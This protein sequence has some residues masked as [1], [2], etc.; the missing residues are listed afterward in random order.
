M[1]TN[2]LKTLAACFVAALM[3]VA[4]AQTALADHDGEKRVHIKKI[5]KCEDGDCTE[6]IEN[7]DHGV[8]VIVD[9]D[10]SKR[11]HVKKIRCDGE[12]CEEHDGAHKMI[13][14]GDGDVEIMSGDEGYSWFSG[15]GVHGGGFLGVG[16]TELTSE[17]REHFGAPGD[18]GVMVSKVMDNSPAFKAGL[19]VGDIITGVDGE[20][21]SNGSAL[22]RMI[23][24]HAE[25]DEVV[26]SVLR[27]GATQSITAAIEEREGGLHGA[28]MKR[29]HER[30][31][32]MHKRVKKIKIQCDSEDGDCRSNVD[33]AGLDDFD[34]GGAEECEVHVECRDGDCTCTVNGEDTDCSGIPGVPG[35]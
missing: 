27:D 14:V 32:D 13:F 18:A 3:L 12:D 28:H 24:G 25:G 4:A 35:R 10:M 30:M 1:R 33:V 26:L 20:D 7:L 34:C 23:R 9:G 2:T 29:L 16:L 17:L 6:S 21:V 22:A 19:S 5:V 31:G 15:H 8:E 11:V